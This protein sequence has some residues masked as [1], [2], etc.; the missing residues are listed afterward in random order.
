MLSSPSLDQM[1]LLIQERRAQAV[2][3]ALVQQARAA[4]AARRMT[5]QSRLRPRMASALRH[6]AYRLDSSL[7]LSA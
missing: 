6:L 4:A 7:A 2:H 5:H 3:A 1:E